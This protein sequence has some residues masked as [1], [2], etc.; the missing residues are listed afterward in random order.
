MNFQ[1]LLETHPR[2]ELSDDAVKLI[3]FNSD[4]IKLDGTFP[5]VLFGDRAKLYNV[6]L[7]RGRVEGEAGGK[8]VLNG[9]VVFQVADGPMFPILKAEVVGEDNRPSDV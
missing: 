4:D 1:P 6:T 9:Q 2:E 8:T 5:A 3:E 7:R